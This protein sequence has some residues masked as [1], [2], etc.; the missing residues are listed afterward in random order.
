MVD[1]HIHGDCVDSWMERAT[2]GL[3]PDRQ[4]QAFDG[5]F[6][7]LWN[8]ANRTLADVTLMA[9]LDRVL[10]VAAEQYPFLCELKV[11]ANGLCCRH[12]HAHADGLD[13]A[14]LV[15]GIRFVLVEFLTVLGN[16]TAEILTPALHSELLKVAPGEEGPDES[17]A[18]GDAQDPESETGEERAKS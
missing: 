13:R 15:A 7:V 11:E 12:M 16:L 17:G 4:L 2:N 10:H 18:R 6:A 9:I 5:G 14:Q 3:P 1:A 8:R